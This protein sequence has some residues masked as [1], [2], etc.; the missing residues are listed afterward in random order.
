MVSVLQRV[1][2]SGPCPRESWTEMDLLSPEGLQGEEGHHASVKEVQGVSRSGCWFA[3]AAGSPYPL[4][5]LGGGGKAGRTGRST[6][7]PG[8]SSSCS[9]PFTASGSSQL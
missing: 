1:R 8:W 6:R 5:G 7:L 2:R 4:T 3:C 9:A